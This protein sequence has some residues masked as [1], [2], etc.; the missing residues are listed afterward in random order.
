[1]STWP[2]PSSTAFF[3]TARELDASRR[4]DDMKSA[5]SPD[6]RISATVFLPRS[7]LRPTTKTW[8]PSWA[9]LLASARPI[10]LVPPVMSA[11]EAFVVINTSPFWFRVGDYRLQDRVPNVADGHYIPLQR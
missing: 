7:A 5:W 1:I 11:V 8:M 3:A 2:F 4:S 10:P 6:P 9:S